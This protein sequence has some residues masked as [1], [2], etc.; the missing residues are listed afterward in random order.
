[1][2][3]LF[4]FSPVTNF[5]SSSWYVSFCS[6]TLN[7]EDF[8]SWVSSTRTSFSSLWSCSLLAL[9]SN[10]TVAFI[11]MYLSWNSTSLASSRLPLGFGL[12][13]SPPPKNGLLDLSSPR[14]TPVSFAAP[15]AGFSPTVNT[16]GSYA[17]L[18]LVDSF[19]SSRSPPSMNANL[20]APRPPASLL[21]RNLLCLCLCLCLRWWFEVRQR[22]LQERQRC[23][24]W[25]QRVLTAKEVEG[26]GAANVCH[27]ADA[28]FDD[29][30]ADEHAV[31]AQGAAAE[32]G[33]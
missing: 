2:A 1:M 11:F 27:W 32:A 10:H 28:P 22:V 3:P 4:L 19:P 23:A 5:V 7:M 24:A 31:P 26:Q 29:V 17:G 8:T 12:R 16:N 21:R 30:S 6:W 14:P 25:R 15:L 18:P 33:E 9:L 20:M 13:T